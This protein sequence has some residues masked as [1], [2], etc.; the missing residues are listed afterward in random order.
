MKNTAKYL[1]YKAAWE[2]ISSAIEH[3]FYLEAVALCE[4]IISDRLISYV[5]G[6]TGKHVKLET[7]FNHLIGLW[8]TNAGVIAWKD[9]VDLADSVDLWRTKR[10]M[11][12]HGLVKSAPRKPT[13]NVE[14][15]IE[16]ARTSAE[17]GR[18][19]AKAVSAWHK[20]QLANV[21]RG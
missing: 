4:S 5:H 1:S 17:Q 19:L 10:N 3:G 9:H 2:R 6:V 20:K 8:R 18:E 12:V 16:L 21:S 11:V 15:F 13:Q 7:Q 14:S